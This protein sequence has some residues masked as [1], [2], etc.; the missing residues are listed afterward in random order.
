MSARHKARKRALDIL[1]EAEQRGANLGEVLDERLSFSGAQTPLPLYSEQIVRGVLSRWVE[2]NQIIETY[3]QE[4]TLSRLPAVDRAIL[5]LS[6]WE[7]SYNLE[8]DPTVAISEALELATELSTDD[9]PR[10]I[11]GVLASVNREVP[12]D[13]PVEGFD[14]PAEQGDG[15]EDY[16]PSLDAEDVADDEADQADAAVVAAVV[17][18]A[19]ADG[20]AEPVILAEPPVVSES[21]FKET[22]L[23]EEAK[24]LNF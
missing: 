4:W 21:G 20:D 12:R 16:V 15:D 18:S 24:R 7:L 9:S 17:D 5:R 22:T 1:F 19:V 2:I 14:A 3:A 13:L 23:E 11:N 10:F 6:V 8:I